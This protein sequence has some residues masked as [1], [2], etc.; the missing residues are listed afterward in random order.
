MGW[1]FPLVAQQSVTPSSI[2][3]CVDAKGR[4]ITSD[5]PNME[6]LDREQK[7][8]SP[9][10]TVKGSLPPSLTAE[11]RAAE[12]EKTRIAEERR[13]RD[14][15]QKRRDRSLLNRYPDEASHRRERD[16]ALS[17]V[18][19]A[20]LSGQ[21]RVADLMAQREL[22][23]TERKAAG[24]DLVKIGRVRRAF[25]ENEQN[26]AAQK[27]LLAAQADERQR[28]NKRFDDELGRLKGLWAQNASAVAARSAASAASAPASRSKPRT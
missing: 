17:R 28:I 11:E 10:G 2:Y 5:R 8:Y 18:D 1:G 26:L 14:A 4:R 3:S 15:E 6:C 24:S 12:D 7:Q 20:T 27:R 13:L 16:D 22:I 23:E 21:Q 9:S 19:S 25:E